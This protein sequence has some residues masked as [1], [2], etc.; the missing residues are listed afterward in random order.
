MR[1]MRPEQQQALY[2]RIGRTFGKAGEA[3]PEVNRAQPHRG[4][5]ADGMLPI[6]QKPK[7]IHEG[8]LNALCMVQN[9]MTRAADA[10]G[11]SGH[12]REAAYQLDDII[13]QVVSRALVITQ[14]VE[15]LDHIQYQQLIDGAHADGFSKGKLAAIEEA[16]KQIRLEVQRALTGVI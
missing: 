4:M 5:D 15:P 14:R 9:E 12:L 6:N 11:D 8:T 16:R 1:K 7:D 10:E 13:D 3:K 2:N